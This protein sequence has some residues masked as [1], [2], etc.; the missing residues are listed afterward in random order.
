[1]RDRMDGLIELVWSLMREE[2]AEA[3]I[4]AFDTSKMEEYAV[5]AGVS[6]ARRKSM[7]SSSRKAQGAHTRESLT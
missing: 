6:G 7:P 4:E 1:M 2:R 3:G 5:R